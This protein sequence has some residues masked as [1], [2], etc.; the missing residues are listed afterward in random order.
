MGNR[1]RTEGAIKMKQSLA[2]LTINIAGDG[3]LQ[4]SARALALV[5]SLWDCW[6]LQLRPIASEISLLIHLCLLVFSRA[7]RPVFYL[8]LVLARRQ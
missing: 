8:F 3:Q 4:P 1:E 2:Q 5:G 7:A 6:Q